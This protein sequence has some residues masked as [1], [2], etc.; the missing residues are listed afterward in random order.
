[1]R[2]PD[3]FSS[4]GNRETLQSCCGQWLAFIQTST[5]IDCGYN[6]I[7]AVGNAGLKEQKLCSVADLMES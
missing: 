2:G 7:E 5:K 1:M 3:I 4:S 6:F